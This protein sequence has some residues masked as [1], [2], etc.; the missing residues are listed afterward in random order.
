MPT[1]NVVITDHQATMIERLVASGRYQNASEVLRDGL[2]LIETREAEA[3]ARLQAL[4]DAVAVGIRDIEEGRY[5][6]YDSA[7]ALAADLDE[8]AEEAF[9]AA[10]AA[11]P[12]P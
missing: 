3:A 2:R 8:I 7:E 6:V 4:R 1:R 12:I 11:G 5:K 10:K 9:A